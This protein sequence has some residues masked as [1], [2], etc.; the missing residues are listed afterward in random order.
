ML[1]EKCTERVVARHCWW[2]SVLLLVLTVLLLSLS[3]MV[4][5]LAMLDRPFPEQFQSCYID[6][7]NLSA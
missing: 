1:S 6:V 3:G 2:N 5:A 7:V 4:G